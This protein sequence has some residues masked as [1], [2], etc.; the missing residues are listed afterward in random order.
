LGE[1]I[2]QQEIRKIKAE[3]LTLREEVPTPLEATMIFVLL[4]WS[5]A[6]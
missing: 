2:L 6:N 1:N 4:H 3:E 5:R